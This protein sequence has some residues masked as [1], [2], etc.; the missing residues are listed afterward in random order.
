MIPNKDYYASFM[1]LPLHQ[2]NANLVST[3]GWLLTK[4]HF[5]YKLHCTVTNQLG[6]SL[7]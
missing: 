2:E 7:I 3:K 5:S 1:D 6:L 4:D